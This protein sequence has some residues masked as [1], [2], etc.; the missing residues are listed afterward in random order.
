M[1]QNCDLTLVKIQ[2]THYFYRYP[3]LA[4]TEI[5]TV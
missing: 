4:H 1:L 2:L 5:I 3:N